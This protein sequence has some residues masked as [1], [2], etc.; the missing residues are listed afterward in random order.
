MSGTL[1]GKKI[2]ITREEKQGKR[3]AEMVE[4]QGGVP[5]SVPL[6][7]ISCNPSALKQDF[8][9]F[10]AYKWLFFTSANGVECFFRLAV[11]QGV[12][13][14]DFRQLKIAAVGPRTEA[15]LKPYGLKADFIP[16]EY[17]AEVMASEF[18]PTYANQEPVL[19]VRGN[20]SLGLLP[21]FFTKHLMDFDT[22]EVYETAPY[23]ANAEKL[24]EE[25]RSGGID[26]LTFAS[27]SAAKV[28]AAYTEERSLPAI[29]IGTTTGKRAIEL[30]FHSVLMPEEFSLDGMLA[31]ID[32]DILT[33][34]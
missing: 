1:K 12:K 2:L 19:L 10:L 32:K 25:L 16:S 21:E 27:P 22:V 13:P 23:H 26:Y 15:A 29:C 33:K 11:K 20:L 28:F 4:A 31:L 3:F 5:V 34:G 24:E 8:T 14:Q 18:H 7:R 6:L 9:R 30:G 17:S